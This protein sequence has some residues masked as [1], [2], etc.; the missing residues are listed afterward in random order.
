MVYFTANALK[1][2]KLGIAPDLTSDLMGSYSPEDN[3][4]NIVKFTFE[5]DAMY[6]NSISGNTTPY[7][8][9][10]INIF[11]GEVN[12][13]KN[14]TWP[15]Y[16]F[17]SSSSAKELKVGERI[18]HKQTLYHFKGTKEDLNKISKKVLG[19]NLNTIPL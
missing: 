7:S 19:V 14:Y 16:E 4:L 1:L 9:D 8:G 17:E 11:N 18:Y 12:K 10:V 2:G 13:E 15:F 5:N 6:L 3:L